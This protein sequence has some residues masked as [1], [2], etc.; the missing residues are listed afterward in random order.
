MKKNKCTSDGPDTVVL[1][2]SLNE[3]T[4]VEGELVPTIYCDCGR[5]RPAC[6]RKWLFNNNSIET[7]GI[8]QLGYAFPNTAGQ[9]FCQCVNPDTMEEKTRMITLEVECKH[10]MLMT[11][12]VSY[13]LSS[14]TLESPGSLFFCSG[15]KST[16]KIIFNRLSV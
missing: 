9:Y 6:N 4:V 15:L 7:N 5:C 1:V 16:S 2:P 13:S 11:T 14:E 8:L 12:L 10:Y 3:Y